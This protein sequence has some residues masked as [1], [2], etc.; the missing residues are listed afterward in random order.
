[1][2]KHV[3]P[4]A[5]LFFFRLTARLK[6]SPDTK[7]ELV[8]SSSSRALCDAVP[9]G[10]LK[11]TEPSPG[12]Y[13]WVDPEKMCSVPSSR[14]RKLLQSRVLRFRLFQHGN[15]RVCVFPAS[16]ELLIRRFGLRGFALHDIGSTDLEMRQ[17]TDG[18][19]HNHAAMV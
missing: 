5:P 10:R 11:V 4:K 9:K 15:I 12:R 17:Y 16:E 18:L 13:S 19:V 1:M 2:E 3:G 14:D 6:P 7:Q 8:A